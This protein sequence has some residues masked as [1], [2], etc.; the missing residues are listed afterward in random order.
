MVGEP[1][2]FEAVMVVDQTEVE[3]VTQGQPVEL[4]LNSFPW[5]TFRGKVDQI[6][7]THIEA[8]SERLSVKAGGSVPTETDPS[9]REIPISTSYEALMTLDDADAVFTPGMRGTA[10]IQVGSR[11]VGQWLLRLLWQTFNFRM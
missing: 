5:Q 2:R 9:G 6:A 8:G 11:T 1:E 10:R 7:E 4:K 3:F